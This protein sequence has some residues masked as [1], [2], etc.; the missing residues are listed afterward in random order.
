LTSVSVTGLN[1]ILR[2][3][4]CVPLTLHFTFIWSVYLS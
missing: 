4:I 3:V 2:I 1:I